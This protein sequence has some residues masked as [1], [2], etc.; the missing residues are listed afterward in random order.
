M[1]AIVFKSWCKY[2]LN[3]VNPRVGDNHRP[4]QNILLFEFTG[5]SHCLKDKNARMAT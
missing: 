5:N 3:F 1:N 4:R 2:T